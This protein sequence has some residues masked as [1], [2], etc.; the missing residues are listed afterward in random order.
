MNCFAFDIETIPD[1]EFGRKMWD[2]EGL[3]DED[4]GNTMMFKQK[5][6]TNS[7][8]LPL[9]QHKIVAISVALR[10][11]DTFKVWSLGDEE[12]PESEIV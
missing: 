4:I 3:S 2:L 7:E 12:A 8:F 10:N 1:V 11:K 6:K 5:Q 9:H